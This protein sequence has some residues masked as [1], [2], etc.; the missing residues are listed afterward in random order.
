MK[1]AGWKLMNQTILCIDE[2]QRKNKIS[3]DSKSKIASLE[4]LDTMH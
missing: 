3:F 4:N 1:D 2:N